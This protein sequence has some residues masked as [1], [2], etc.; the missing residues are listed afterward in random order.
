MSGWNPTRNKTAVKAAGYKLGIWTVEEIDLLI[1]NVDMFCQENNI[2]D[3]AEV[4]FKYKKDERKN[5]YK[6]VAI[7]FYIFIFKSAVQKLKYT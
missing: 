6:K 2:T 1:K 7:F 3:P 4:I 5:F